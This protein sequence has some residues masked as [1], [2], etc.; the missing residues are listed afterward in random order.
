MGMLDRGRGQVRAKVVIDTKR[1]TLVPNIAKHVK[2]GSNVYTDEAVQAHRR[3]AAVL[4]KRR[5]ALGAGM[6]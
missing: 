3:R 4:L 2:H 1:D 5:T 6:G